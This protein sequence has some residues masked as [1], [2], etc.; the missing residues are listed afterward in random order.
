[1]T[2]F[3][4]MVPESEITP[5]VTKEGSE[6]I[7]VFQIFPWMEPFY[8]EWEKNYDVAAAY[9][10][11]AENSWV[12]IVSL[13]LYLVFIVAGTKIMENRKAFDLKMP[14]AAWN[15]F[16]S[17]FSFW[18]MSRVVPHL[19]YMMYTQT[20]REQ[21]CTPPENA[22]GDG[23]AGLWVMLFCVSKVFEL[24][25]TVFI[26]LRKKPLMFLHWYHHVTVLLYTWFSYSKRNPGIHFVGMNYS[27]H[28]F[29]YGYYF[30]MAVK[31]LPKWF[32]PLWL[33]SAQINQMFVGVTITI[34]SYQYKKADPENCAVKEEMLLWCG[35]MY[36]TYFY[37][38]VEFAVKRF[39]FGSHKKKNQ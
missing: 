4:F 37:L 9:Q 7:Q 11:V 26:V 36:G 32:N 24:I 25:D 3:R 15:L 30:L 38:F 16:L 21:A 1:M 29:M 34:L 12:P 10:W 31:L 19:L 17:L 33:T 8:M 13:V 20:I 39:I 35:L 2:G 27:V 14:L 22:Y 6:F 23:A 28:A 18:G 5:Y